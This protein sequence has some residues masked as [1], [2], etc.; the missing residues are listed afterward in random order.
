[1]KIALFGGAFDPPHLGHKI[2]ANSLIKNKI[3]DEV[4]FVPV[5]KH[6]WADRYGKHNLT[7]YNDRV[8]MLD[9]NIH[10]DLNSNSKKEHLCKS[11]SAGKDIFLKEHYLS[12][13]QLSEKQKIAH[14]KDISFTFNTL[15]YFSKSYSEHK[16]SW[17]MGSEY[18]NR[19]DDFLKGHPQLIDYPFYIYPRAGF[20]FNEKLKK[21]NMT[22]LYDMPEI[23]ASSSE[24]KKLVRDNENIS[25]L[26]VEKVEEFILENKLYLLKQKLF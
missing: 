25:D 19:F 11:E 15:E 14:Y 7:D 24:I 17:V 12:K 6:P 26:V 18:L 8:A 9:L 16:F 22:F 10:A 5:F 1:M 4:W 20:V 23:K 21:Q 2:V 13:K 3:V